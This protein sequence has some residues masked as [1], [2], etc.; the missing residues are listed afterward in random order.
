MT[1]EGRLARGKVNHESTNPINAKRLKN[2]SETLEY[3]ESLANEE[4]K[5]EEENGES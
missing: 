1:V 3:V 4:P 2:N 5:E